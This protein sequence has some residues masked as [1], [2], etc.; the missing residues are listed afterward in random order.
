MV[1]TTLTFEKKDNV[2][3]ITFN[4]PEIHNAFNGTVISEMQDVFDSIAKDDSIRVVVLT[5]KGKSFCAGADLNWMRGVIKQSFDENLAESNALADLFYSIYRCKR[6]VIGRINGAAIGGGTGFVA[7]CDIAIASR[8]AIFSFSEV[9]IGVVPACI[10][11]YVIKK[12]GEGKARELFITGERMRGDRAFEVGLV[13]KVVDD[14]QLD[15]D[16]EDLIQSILSSGPEAVAM[17]KRLVAEVPSMSPEEFKPY[18]AEMIARLRISDEGQEGMDAFLNK[19]KPN[20]T[21]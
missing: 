15:Q 2:A 16:V 20:W 14:D 9:K 11:P 21:K 13:N 17:A 18:T 7:V 6:P 3:R 10:G 19:R 1:Y 12:M 8:S 5:G 4:R